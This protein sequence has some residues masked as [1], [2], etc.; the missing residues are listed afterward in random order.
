MTSYPIRLPETGLLALTKALQTFNAD[1]ASRIGRLTP[2]EHNAFIDAR[3]R[4]AKAADRIL[5]AS[6]AAAR[7][8]TEDSSAGHAEHHE[9]TF[10]CL[11]CAHRQLG[12]DE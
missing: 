2:A 9:F 5:H 10:G 4:I 3:R 7:T 11:A 8:V 1:D 6:N 12:F